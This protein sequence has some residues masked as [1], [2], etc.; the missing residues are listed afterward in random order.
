MASNVISTWVVGFVALS[1]T[2]SAFAPVAPYSTCPPGER[3]WSTDGT[4]Y[5]ESSVPRPRPSSESRRVRPDRRMAGCRAA[6]TAL[7]TVTGHGCLGVDHYRARIW[8]RCR[9]PRSG[10]GWGQ[11]PVQATKGGA[12][13]GSASGREVEV[14]F[15]K[16]VGKNSLMEQMLK[17]A[18]QR[19]HWQEA[20][21]LFDKMK[22]EGMSLDKL[23]YV[24]ALRACSKGAAWERAIQLFDNCIE[25]GYDLDEVMVTSAVKACCQ[26]GRPVEAEALLAKGVARG[27]QPKV[28][29]YTAV[30][31]AC[32]T[33]GDLDGILAVADRLRD[34]RLKP[35]H[36]TYHLMVTSHIGRLDWVSATKALV[37]MS[38]DGLVP[39][40]R[41]ARQWR[42]ASAALEEVDLDVDERDGEKAGTREDEDRN[43]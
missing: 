27:V 20:I 7:M 25:E 24:A 17:T 26:A 28:S 37:D 36:S 40:K 42:L 2:C 23:A 32:Y 9:R 6:A 22:A 31:N 35:D 16:G 19:Q 38:K 29:L 1:T 41:S 15:L 14:S 34:Q 43:V 21:D 10:Q 3:W 12:G 33:V 5:K 8:R 13:G 4:L 11:A 18:G 39:S 30:M